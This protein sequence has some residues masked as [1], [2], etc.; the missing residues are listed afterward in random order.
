MSLADFPIE[1]IR[2]QFP[3]L[4]LSDDGRPRIYFDNPAGTQVPTQVLDRMRRA[5]VETN[6]NLGGYFATTLANEETY[7]DAHSAMADFLNA[8]SPREIVFGANM[9]T[10]TLHVSRSLAKRLRPGD[11][12]VVT[13]MDHDANISPWLLIARDTGAVIRWLDFDLD[14]YR[15]PEDG[16]DQV[17]S[18]RTK[19]V[20]IGAASNCTGTINDVKALCAQARAAGALVY[21]DAV[22]LAPHAG[23][24]VQEMG[25]DFLVC[26]PYKFFG[27]HQGVL[28]GRAALL[29][30]LDPYKVRPAGDDLPE[31]FET[32]TPSFEGAAGTL[33]AIDYFEWVGAT[34]APQSST[35]AHLSA[36]GAAVHR[37]MDFLAAYE[38]ELTRHLISRLHEIDG[39]VVRGI[40][41]ANEMRWRVPTVSVTIEGR[42]PGDLARG[43]AAENM[44]VWDGH[45]YALEPVRR[46][47]LLDTG[48]VLRI[49]LAHYNTPE[50]VDRFAAA[51][52]RLL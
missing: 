27:P 18:E 29:M 5:M 2:A 22:Q 52:E 26:S 45:N 13:R 28:W 24:D 40:T 4:S 42:H 50:E 47:G 9:T 37:A 32:G 11:E 43:L 16:L 7:M 1:Q 23:I 39:L 3:A 38:L 36:R 31:R 49:G 44:F 35:H 33:G 46:M 12:I 6:A 25:C 10:L 30:A 41:A 8:P 14:T 20:C 17:L 34:L 19:L 21:V 51:L 15:F 48:G